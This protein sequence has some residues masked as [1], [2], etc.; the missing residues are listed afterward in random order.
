MKEVLNVCHLLPRLGAV[1]TQYEENAI[2]S[3]VHG[4]NRIGAR[5]FPVLFLIMH[6]LHIYITMSVKGT[7]E[8][9]LISRAKK[10]NL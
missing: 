5:T 8:L 1:S 6:V 7:C 4:K 2:E 3:S 9:W 10:K